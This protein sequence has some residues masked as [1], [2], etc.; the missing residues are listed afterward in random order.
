MTS[1]LLI[2]P[3]WLGHSGLW[4]VDA[5]GR[6]KPVDAED[7]DLSEEL[8][9]RLEAWMD[10]FDAIYDED[11]ETRSRFADAVQQLAWEAEGAAIAEAVRAELGASWTVE[12]DLASWQENLKS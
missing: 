12:T 2:A 11:D 1:T 10:Q 9:D 4:L 7:V 3:A 6:R 8:A 5:K